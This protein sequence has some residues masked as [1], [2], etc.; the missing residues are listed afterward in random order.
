M[1]K[2][3]TFSIIVPTRGRPER[4]ALLLESIK[5]T[6]KDIDS[7]EVLLVIDEDD[8]STMQFE[9]TGV[10]LKRVIVSPGLPMGALNMAGY[11]VSTARYIMLLNDDVIVRTLTWDEKVLEAFRNFPDEIVLVH[12]NDRIFQDKLCTFP[13]LSR[14]FCELAGGICPYDYVRY[15]IDDHIYNIFNLLSVLGRT[16]ILYLPD[17]IFEHTNFVVSGTGK[18]QYLPNKEIHAADT[19]RFDSLLGVRKELAIRLAG[20]IDKH[21]SREVEDIRRKMLFQITDSISIRL[22]EYVSV[23]SEN[24]NF[25]SEKSR[26]TIGVVSANFQ[27]DHARICMNRV[28]DFTRNF[29]LIVLD[30]NGG[31]GFNHSREMNRIISICKTDFLV[32]MDDDVFVEPGWLDGMLRCI[33]Q[34][35]GVV[36]PFHKNRDGDFSYSGIVMRPD[37]SGDHAHSLAKFECPTP[38]QTL[39]SAILLIDIRKCGHIRF[40]ESYSKYFLDIDYG[41]RVWETGFRVVC[42]PFT[43]VTHLGGATLQQGSH[44]SNVLFDRQRQHFV[45]T[46]IQT[47]RYKNIEQ[48]AWGRIPALKEILDMPSELESLVVRNPKESLECFYK[49]AHVYFDRLKNYPVLIDY[50]RQRIWD[51]V[52]EKRPKLDDPKLGHLAF[53]LGFCGHPVLMGQSGNGFNIILWN[54]NYYAILPR[55]GPFDPDRISKKGYTLFYQAAT[56]ELLKAQINSDH[57]SQARSVRWSV[58]IPFQSQRG[59]RILSVFYIVPR[60]LK[61]LQEERKRFGAWK[62]AIHMTA[63]GTLKSLLVSVLGFEGFDRLKIKWRAIGV[64]DTEKSRLKKVSQILLMVLCRRGQST[65]RILGD[66]LR[67]RE[68]NHEKRTHMAMVERDIQKWVEA[69]P[70]TLIGESYCGYSIY[71]FEYKYFAVPESDGFFDYEEFKRGGYEKCFV[72]NNLLE[73]RGAIQKNVEKSNRIKNEHGLLLG[74]LPQEQLGPLYELARLTGQITLLIG[75]GQSEEWKQF[76]CILVEGDTVY[77]WILK[78]GVSGVS[79]IHRRITEGAINRV[80]LPSSFPETWANNLLEDFVSKISNRLDVIHSSGEWRTYE[81]ENVHRLVY[82]KA[83]LAS[84]FQVVGSPAGMS[85]LEVGCSDGLVCDLFALLGVERV[86]GIDM[87][88]TVGCNFPNKK[89]DYHVRN[90]EA[91]GFPDQSF[92]LVYTI[93]TLEHVCDPFKVLLEMLRVTKVGGYGYAQAGPLYHSPFGHHMFCYFQNYPWIHLRKTKE[94]IKAYVNEHGIDKAI[95]RDFG[96]NCEEYIDSMLNF[97]HV[98]GLFLEEYRLDEF[99]SRDDIRIL[100]FNLSYEGRELLDAK[101]LD[102]MSNFDHSSLVEHGFEILFQRKK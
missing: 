55:E 41:L 80:I 66:T 31:S 93:A 39:C 5:V 22:P 43:M 51:L 72:G 82:N 76:E 63:K 33:D 71:R 57:G 96:L 13:F 30:N 97:N 36:T 56:L 28:K 87:M 2:Q 14:T 44:L 64:E 98:N 60:S 32:L 48:N 6:T 42:S 16:R 11:E 86:T 95:K 20:F 90:A 69:S 84:L 94:E 79:N 9:Y 65:S 77:D 101:I 100:K 10:P 73:V 25:T 70:V 61:Q 45:R 40:D 38:I 54:G 62:P 8:E 46:W 50:F 26:V 27:S 18:V 92:D 81:G 102:E 52:G 67:L 49:R 3:P 17:V 59:E 91:T 19:A 15:R 75:Q 35:V 4:L 7:I 85:V 34:T 78:C 12:V 88:K 83:Y 23:I 89:I 58:F 24:Q 99:R 68:K 53:L 37:Y 47:K 74:S 1:D 21:L 29:D